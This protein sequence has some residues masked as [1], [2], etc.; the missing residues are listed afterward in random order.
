MNGNVAPSSKK[1]TAADTEDSGNPTSRAIRLMVASS[2]RCLF[3]RP[4][5]ENQDFWPIFQKK[6][7]T[8]KTRRRAKSITEFVWFFLYVLQSQ[9][10]V[11]VLRA[12]GPGRN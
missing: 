8:L 10:L 5:N 1:E 7:F 12:K 3:Y 11:G 2:M 4:R 9:R 6:R